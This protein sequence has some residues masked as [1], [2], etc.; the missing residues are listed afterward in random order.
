MLFADGN[1]ILFSIISRFSH[2]T[3]IGRIHEDNT[4]K[5]GKVEKNKREKSGSFHLVIVYSSTLGASIFRQISGIEGGSTKS[6]VPE[7]NTVALKMMASGR[8]LGHV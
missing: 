6:L 5:T 8:F 4:E 1:H 7:R 3:A 2:F